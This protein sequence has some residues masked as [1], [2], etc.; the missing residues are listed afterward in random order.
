MD[1]D[2]L[3]RGQP[4]NHKKFGEATAILAGD[5]LLALAFE[6]L[7]T[8]VTDPARSA[9]LT[10][11]L[12]RGAGWRGMIG[13]QMADLLGEDQAPDLETVRSIHARKTGA[14]FQA[15]CRMGGIAGGGTADQL[16]RL[17]EY[18]RHMGLAFQIADDVL[19]VSSTAT[20]LG[21]SVGK[22]AAQSKQ[23]YPACVGISESRAMAAEEVAAAIQSLD[24]FGPRAEDLRDL[25]R[26]AL[27]REK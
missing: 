9:A 16:E 12:A 20:R 10:A 2:D 5:A 11:E 26:F 23:T 3:R 14:L 19:D 24:E 25:A 7:A 15:A 21:K 8:R 18:G 13:G 6:T 4:T 22:D 27:A 1:N 17:G